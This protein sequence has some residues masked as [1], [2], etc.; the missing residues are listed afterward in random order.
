MSIIVEAPTNPEFTA[1][2][3]GLPAGN[4]IDF[5]TALNAKLQSIYDLLQ[6]DAAFLELLVETLGNGAISG[7]EV[8]A[9]VGLSVSVA[10][11]SALIGTI[12]RTDAATTVGGLADNAFNYLY[13]RQDGTWSTNTTGTPPTSADGHGQ[14][15]QWAIVQTD[16]GAVTQIDNSRAIFGSRM[17]PAGY[18]AIAMSDA[19]YTLSLVEATNRVLEFTG[20][21]TDDREIIL[22]D[23]AF[24]EFLLINSTTGGHWLLA[25]TPSGTGP[26]IPP[27]EQMMVY[28]DGT[29]MVQE[30]PRAMLPY[31]T[32]SA[33]TTATFADECLFVD[34]TSANVTVTLPPVADARGREILVKKIDSSGHT[35]TIDGDGSETIDGATTKVLSSQWDSARIVSTASFWYVV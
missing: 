5:R 2:F 20:A 7:G 29:D 18:L 27:G 25:R 32:V 35:V 14:A 26:T 24:H 9:G 19:N 10:T 6:V 4:A 34:A 28:C 30:K 23:A 13:A 31:R 16:T 33:D 12:I 8:S 15:L 1:A 11:Y 22:P 21:L 3:S 17:L